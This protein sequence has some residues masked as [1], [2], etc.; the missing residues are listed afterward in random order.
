MMP[1]TLCMAS[2]ISFPPAD[3]KTVQDPAHD[4][5]KQCTKHRR[6]KSIDAEAR[7][8]Q[9]RQSKTDCVED[10]DEEPER[11]KRQWQGQEEQDGPDDGVDESEDHELVKQGEGLEEDSMDVD[12]SDID[13]FPQGGTYPS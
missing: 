4:A 3:K 12:E 2:L 6:E 8:Q 1:T 11:E 10:E 13:E 7:H 5:D 9:S